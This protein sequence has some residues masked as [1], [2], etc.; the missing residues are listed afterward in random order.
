MDANVLEALGDSKEKLRK[1]VL[2]GRVRCTIKK[3]STVSQS[4]QDGDGYYAILD[5]FAIK[6]LD[7]ANDYFGKDSWDIN[8]IY[9]TE[10]SVLINIDSPKWIGKMVKVYGK[11]VGWGTSLGRQ[12]GAP[13]ESGISALE[14]V[15]EG[16]KWG[17]TPNALVELMDRDS[18]VT[19]TLL[20]SAMVAVVEK[21]TRKNPSAVYSPTLES[22]VPYS[23]VEEYEVL[24]SDTIANDEAEKQ[25]V[26][27]AQSASIKR[28]DGKVDI[29]SIDMHLVF[30]LDGQEISPYYESIKECLED[31]AKKRKDFSQKSLDEVKSLVETY[32]LVD[33]NVIKD[34]FISRIARDCDQRLPLRTSQ[35][36]MTVR[37]FVFTVIDNCTNNIL[38]SND[39][40]NKFSDK[41]IASW[42]IGTEMMRQRVQMDPN[43]FS[44]H[45]GESEIDSIPMLKD[46][47]P[48][49]VNVVGTCTGIGFDTLCHNMIYFCKNLGVSQEIWMFMLL[50]CPYYLGL[51]GTGMGVVECDILYY[52]FAK[53]F[54]KSGEMEEENKTYRSYLIFLDTLKS[55]SD[56]EKQTFISSSRYKNSRGG[57]APQASYPRW[58]KKYLNSHNFMAKEDIKAVLSLLLGIDI[59]APEDI[60]NP[61]GWCSQEIIKTLE[62]AGVTNTLNEGLPDERYGLERDIEREF[63]IY[64]VFS[65]LGRKETG[66]T[67]ETIEKV[68]AQFEKDRG[69]KLEG[70]QREGIKLCKKR[71][72]VL[73]GCAG[74]G[75]TTTSDCITE[76]LKT[77]GENVKIIYCTPTGKACRR[78]AEV[79]HS[80]VK[81]IHSQFGVGVGGTSY[82]AGGYSRK[83]VASAEPSIYI[84]DEMA[85]CSTDLMYYIARKVSDN[86]M[87]YF[88]GDVKQL[89]PIGGGCPFRM[90]M[91][92][93]P[94]VELGVSK[95]AAEGSLV[96]YNTSLINFMSDGILEE[97]CYDGKTFIDRECEGPSI[98]SVT[99]QVFKGLM[100]GSLN[101]EKYLEDDIQIISA[102]KNIGE[103]GKQHYSATDALNKPIQDFLRSGDK[104]LYYKGG[105]NGAELEPFYQNDRVIYVNQ[106]SYGICRYTLINGDLHQVPTFGCVNG[107]MGKL[108]GIIP[109][110][111]IKVVPYSGGAVA[112][113]GFYSGV[114]EEE[115]KSI[116]ERFEGRKDD[117]R[118]D[119][120]FA[121]KDY[122]FV[123]VQVYD[124]DLRQNIIVLL[125][126]KGRYQEGTL[127]LSG[128]DLNNLELAYALTCHKMQ[129]SQSKVVV[130][131]FEQGSSSFVNRNMINTIITRSQGVVCCIGSIKGPNSALNK[132]RKNVS[133]TV[134]NDMLNVLGGVIAVDEEGNF[135]WV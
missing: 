76:V 18:D 120:T 124:T 119:D 14:F 9:F 100:G 68:I 27:K 106:N 5:T 128:E 35:A 53:A 46:V 127:V 2:F 130:A 45:S 56:S 107:E 21:L 55:D 87:I 118:H 17:I 126:A 86:D 15:R 112:G 41:Q 132:G 34:N 57:N 24:D 19:G 51:L 77:L 13:R 73:S 105:R 66:I 121:Q 91:E 30:H 71:A 60:V 102:Y 75:K 20:E 94:C 92:I 129:G 32:G 72:G 79:V 114:S 133:V 22:I 8:H 81:T 4:V 49:V 61:D 83:Q 67:D 131:V 62:E 48:F 113:K 11:K 59:Y 10:G 116:L 93:L 52:S 80:T 7:S 28:V 63:L 58:N 99:S 134:R 122:Y 84:L 39:F 43:V 95:R 6:C 69:F 108:I 1:L 74:S 115:L 23:A 64:E 25:E 104:V 88:L 82:L 103:Q 65:Q 29:S 42:K 98:K 96:N 33:C 40:Q 54:N 37:P 44:G 90:L 125:R 26:V 50:R 38:S 85:M 109:C 123:A 97:L 12:Y 101:G 110:S 16:D 36:K 47:I 31:S 3:P 89:P 70:L 117:L 78:L 135:K 111:Q